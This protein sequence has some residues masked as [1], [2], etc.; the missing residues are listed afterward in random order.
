LATVA[1]AAP[2]VR[3]VQSPAVVATKQK[4]EGVFSAAGRTARTRMQVNNPFFVPSFSPVCQLCQWIVSNIQTTIHEGVE[5]LI[6]DGAN[7]Y[8]QALCSATFGEEDNDLLKRLCSRTVSDAICQAV[9][10]WDFVYPEPSRGDRYNAR[11][12]AICT[13]VGLCHAPTCPTGFTQGVL[14]P[15]L[16]VSD[17]AAT[18][19]FYPAVFQNC[20]TWAPG[21]HLCTLNEITAL[22]A[23]EL[24][25]FAEEL[26]VQYGTFVP[27]NGNT[28]K[29]VWLQTT[30]NFAV[31]PGIHEQYGSAGQDPRVLIGFNDHSSDPL[32]QVAIDVNNNGKIGVF[33]WQQLGASFPATVIPYK[34]PVSGFSDIL[35]GTGFCC[36]PTQQ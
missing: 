21:S 2:S 23:L 17:V 25:S 10:V 12:N 27:F 20:S 6:T 14:D 34:V 13:N 33:P 3:G 1:L 19:D 29:V 5:Y 15:T 22:S 28:L 24:V 9:Q 11:A 16:C 36:A 4:K 8:L 26:I 32:F 30:A 35:V 18:P 7:D 31:L